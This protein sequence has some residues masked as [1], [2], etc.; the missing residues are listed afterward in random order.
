[1]LYSIDGVVVFGK[2][3][4]VPASGTHDFRDI[5]NQTMSLSD[6][7]SAVAPLRNRDRIVVDT[8]SQVARNMELGAAIIALWREYVI[9][10]GLGGQSLSQLSAMG[11][12]I[13]ALLSGCLLEAGII[14]SSLPT[15]EVVTADIKARFQAACTSADHIVYG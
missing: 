5:F 9:R 3:V 2:V 1:M 4:E 7:A 6:A 14:I 10:V 8:A 11:S 13:V 15:D 12:V